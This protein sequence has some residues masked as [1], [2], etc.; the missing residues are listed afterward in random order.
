[1]VYTTIQS[2][3]RDCDDRIGNY[4][5]IHALHACRHHPYKASSSIQRKIF[6]Q[7]SGAA[8]SVDRIEYELYVL[9]CDQLSRLVIYGEASAVDL[10][11]AFYDI[12]LGLLDIA[13]A[14][15]AGKMFR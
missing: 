4:E 3:D 5:I 9:H 1:M 12:L 7:V 6:L 8:R 2:S 14:A 13:P 15:K 10:S 11:E